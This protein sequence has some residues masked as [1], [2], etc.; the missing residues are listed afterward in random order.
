M[1]KK[2][3]V[4]THNFLSVIFKEKQIETQKTIHININDLIPYVLIVCYS[5]EKK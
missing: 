3:D 4:K 1:K 5:S 2:T